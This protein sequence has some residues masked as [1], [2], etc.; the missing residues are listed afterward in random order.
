MSLK[1][2]ALNLLIAVSLCFALNMVCCSP[3]FAENDMPTETPSVEL[4]D[5]QLQSLDSFFTLYQ[6][7]LANISAY[8]PMYF[9]VGANPENS[10]FQFSFKYCFFNEKSPL[11]MDHPWLSHMFFAY[12]Q[13]SFWDLKSKSMPF[14]DSSYKP[15]FFYL[16][17]NL[18]EGHESFGGFF[19][20][21]GVQHESNG[22]SEDLSR[23]TNYAYVKP[24]MIF[25]NAK[26]RYG[27]QI[28]PKIWTYFNND[29]DTNPDLKDYRGY[30][31]LQIKFGN[32]DLFVVDNHVWAAKEGMS[33]SA[34]ITYPLSRF[35]KNSLDVYLQLE[36]SN[37][38]AERLLYYTERTDVFR[39][40]FSVVR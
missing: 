26:S 30:M 39:I 33:Y 21:Y 8:N 3:L 37:R 38:L 15:E 20:Q 22:Q 17:K 12:T 25:F 5:Q 19:V 10:K 31:D 1:H 28:A 36:Y 4:K 23:S 7:Y 27:V 16:T 32:A 2:Y 6:P 18:R 11:A 14:D 13:T 24:I 34:D 35:F 40:G 29:N 9:L